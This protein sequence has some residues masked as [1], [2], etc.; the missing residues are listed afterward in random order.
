MRI[1]HVPSTVLLTLLAIM[2][3]RGAPAPT[4][5][6]RETGKRTGKRPSNVDAYQSFE[7]TKFGAFHRKMME[8]LINQSMPLETIVEKSREM[9]ERDQHPPQAGR[10]VHSYVRQFLSDEQYKEFKKRQYKIVQ[11]PSNIRYLA[12]ESGPGSEERVNKRKRA[13]LALADL[14]AAK[15]LSFDMTPQDFAG[16]FKD[17]TFLGEPRGSIAQRIQRTL[18]WK[19]RHEGFDPSWRE[20]FTMKKDRLTRS[21]GRDRPF[22]RLKD[23]LSRAFPGSS[24]VPRRDSRARDGTTISAVSDS[25]QLNYAGE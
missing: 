3:C 20:A 22:K 14:L 11:K 16:T 1:D 9:I 17:T 10:Y 6:K 25:H 4:G 8:A 13:A 2:H 18:M 12:G 19:E 5:P 15:G 23:V 24:E 21:K 7:D